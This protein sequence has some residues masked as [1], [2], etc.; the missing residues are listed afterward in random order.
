MVKD[1]QRYLG[2]IPTLSLI[3]CVTVGKSL[4]FSEPQFPF[5]YN[6]NSDKNF[7]LK[8]FFVKIK[9]DNAY[10]TLTQCL[11]NHLVAVGG[12]SLINLL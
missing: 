11:C 4:T 5:L 6:R 10:S 3:S 8:W 9:R 2:S 7:Y 1:S 12:D